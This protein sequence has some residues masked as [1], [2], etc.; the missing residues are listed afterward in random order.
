MIGISGSIN[1]FNTFIWISLSS[2]NVKLAK[3]CKTFA[4]NVKFLEIRLFSGIDDVKPNNTG[5]CIAGQIKRRNKQL[6][7]KCAA[8]WTPCVSSIVNASAVKTSRNSLFFFRKK[9]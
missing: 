6:E 7:I 2:N 4:I 1:E 5:P 3:F 8:D 9:N